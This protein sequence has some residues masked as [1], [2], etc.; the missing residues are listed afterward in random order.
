MNWN[1]KI[2]AYIGVLALSMLLASCDN[3]DSD[4]SGSKDN[5]VIFNTALFNEK[6]VVY[7]TFLDKD[8]GTYNVYSMVFKGSDGVKLTTSDRSYSINYLFKD[9]V[10]TLDYTYEDVGEDGSSYT[11]VNVHYLVAYKY[12]NYTYTK[13]GSS[14]S[15]TDKAYS[16]CWF[17]KDEEINDVKIETAEQASK[18]CNADTDP[19]NDLFVFNG[20]EAGEIADYENKNK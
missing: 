20:D 12:D 8:E 6:T 13:D 7:N 11:H 5:R 1:K 9:N 17:D 2:F 18:A 14:K 16:F 10:L 15:T 4:S 19:R 3:S